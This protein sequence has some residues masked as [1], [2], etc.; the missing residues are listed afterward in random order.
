MD[1]G[2][3]YFISE[4]FFAD[5]PD[6]FL[7]TNHDNINGAPHDRPYLYAFRDKATGLYWAIPF[8]SQVGKFKALYKSKVKRFGKCDT[9]EFAEVLGFH[10]AFLIQN[11]CPISD[12]YIKSEY[13]RGTRPVNISR[14]D[15]FRITSKAKR[16]L[17]LHR[18]GTKLIFP[19]VLQ[20]EKQLLA[21]RNSTAPTASQPQGASLT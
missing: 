8:S 20:I 11:M 14:D 19:D 17:A 7:M 15:A 18:R 3:F 4:Q 2:H 9:I 6:E 12:R 21:Q 13:L 1:V 10:K 16:V 5:F